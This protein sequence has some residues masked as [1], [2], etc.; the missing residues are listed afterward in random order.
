MFLYLSSWFMR[1]VSKRVVAQHGLSTSIVRLERL[2]GRRRNEQPERNWE[3]LKMDY[4]R[5]R[6]WE[7]QR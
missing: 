6:L 7:S 1:I 3:V 5:N 2:Q 4:R